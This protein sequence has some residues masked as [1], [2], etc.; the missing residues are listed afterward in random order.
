[1]CRG[2]QLTV[3]AFILVVSAGTADNASAQAWNPF[4]KKSAASAAKPK[5][6][7]PFSLDKL[8]TIPGM[9]QPTNRPIHQISMKDRFQQTTQQMWS[10]TK[11]AITPPILQDKGPGAGGIW[12][13]TNAPKTPSFKMPNLFTKT[14]APQGPPPTLNEFLA[15]PRPE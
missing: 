13:F 14:A 12:P 15:Q 9:N 3:A 8:L 2:I 10:D 7:N 4:A 6:A 5:S 11:R 1:M